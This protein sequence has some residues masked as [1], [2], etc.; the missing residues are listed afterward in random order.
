MDDVV[1][2]LFIYFGRIPRWE[3]TTA[4]TIAAHDTTDRSGL[5]EEQKR[6]VQ[7]TLGVLN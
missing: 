3:L 4:W 2:E 7:I 5:T 1:H 6:D